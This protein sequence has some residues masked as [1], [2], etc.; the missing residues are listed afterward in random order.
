MGPFGS[1]VRLAKF[2]DYLYEE[3]KLDADLLMG[4]GL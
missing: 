2:G 3:Y 4:L 1:S